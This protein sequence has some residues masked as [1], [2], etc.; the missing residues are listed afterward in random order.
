[1]VVIIQ[2]Y[3]FEKEEKRSKGGSYFKNSYDIH[4]S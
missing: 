1:M 2:V 4:K 3:K